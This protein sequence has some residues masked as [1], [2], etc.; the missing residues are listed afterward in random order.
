MIE[1][2]PIGWD[3][4]TLL[5]MMEESEGQLSETGFY[6][7]VRDLSLKQSDPIRYEKL[8]A[9]LRGGI[10]D[11]RETAMLIAASPL[12]REMGEVC[13]AVYTPEGDSVALSTGIIV[14]VHTMSEAIKYMVR[15]EYE[16]NP[17]IR[18]RDIF[19][20]NDPLVS[21]VHNADIQTF[22]P[23]FWEGELVAWVAGVT[24]EYDYGAKTPGRRRSDL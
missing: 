4:L 12:V 21:N 2:S 7:G 11:A 19:V 5:E 3:G 22:V 14:H 16:S 24:H 8:Y 17:G 13:F 10:V 1:R 9:R 20:N 6:C 15:N 23:V 18:D